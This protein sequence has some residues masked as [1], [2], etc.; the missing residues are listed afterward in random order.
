MTATPCFSPHVGPP[1]SLC[2][3]LVWTVPEK[4]TPAGRVLAWTCPCTENF[5][6]LRQA[7]GLRFIRRTRR[8]G[9]VEDTRRWAAVVGTAQWSA[10]LMGHLR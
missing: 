6:E 3:P 2:E 10:L 5:Y 9:R 8:N 7:S 4:F 1:A